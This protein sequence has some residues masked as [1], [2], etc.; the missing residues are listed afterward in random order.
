MLIFVSLLLAGPANEKPLQT[1]AT[2]HATYA[3]YAN[4]DLVRIDRSRH[5][6]EISSDELD[7]A[8]DRRGWETVAAKGRF[9]LCGQGATSPL[10]WNIRDRV[11]LI[12]F[13]DIRFVSR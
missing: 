7:K 11:D 13:R 1:C 3:I 2:A 6:I 10:K 8:L 9:T 4:H 5:L 12:S